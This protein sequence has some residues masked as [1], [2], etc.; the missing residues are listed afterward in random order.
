MLLERPDVV[1]ED[2]LQSGRCVVDPVS[3]VERH[4]VTA[5]S[6][7]FSADLGSIIDDSANAEPAH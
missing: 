1:R 6:T 7:D 3:L 5:S 2:L 4:N